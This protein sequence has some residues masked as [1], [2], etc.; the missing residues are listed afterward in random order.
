MIGYSLAAR[1]NERHDLCRAGAQ[2]RPQ[3]GPASKIWI[4]PGIPGGF[5][6]QID[7]I[8]AA[9]VRAHVLSI[10]VVPYVLSPTRRQP[11]TRQGNRV[12]PK[13]LITD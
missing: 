13:C 4:E 9:A 1:L 6:G 12:W 8:D 7:V 10:A 3:I 5:A 11:A 2:F